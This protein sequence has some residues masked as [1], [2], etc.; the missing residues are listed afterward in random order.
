M[1]R[2]Y[3]YLVNRTKKG[4]KVITVLQGE[5]TGPS[6]LT[7]PTILNLPQMWERKIVEVMHEYR[8]NFDAW[9]ESATDFEDLKVKLKERG[10]SDLP[11]GFTPLLNLP[12]YTKAPVACTKGC[13]VRKTMLRKAN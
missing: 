6:R 12:A 2:L 13:A 8:M 5:T 7:D 1:K 3:L 10:Y 9:A 4:I 11:I